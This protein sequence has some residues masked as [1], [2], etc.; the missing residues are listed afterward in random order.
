MSGFD[1]K[2]AVKTVND[3]GDNISNIIADIENTK[4]QKKENDERYEAMLAQVKRVI[5]DI[6]E[7]KK[8]I[9][10]AVMKM[11]VYNKDIATTIR[12]L[13]D[14]RRYIVAS[15]ESLTHLIQILYL[16]QN[17]YYGGGQQIDDVK[18]LLKSDNISDTLS[19]DEI[20]NNLIDQFNSLIGDLTDHQQLYT[21]EYQK[22]TELRAGYKKTVLSYSDKI[23]TLQEQKAYLMDFLKLYKSNKA[24]LDAQMDDLFQTKAQL[25]KKI[26]A[27][28]RNVRDQRFNQSFVNS[29]NYQAFMAL[30]D[31][32]EERKN[33][34]LWPVLPV[35]A[36]DT[37]FADTGA[38]SFEGVKIHAQQFDTIYAPANGIVYKVSDQDGIAV[39]RMMIVHNDGYVTVFTNINKSLV[40]E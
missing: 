32:R 21:Q 18:L 28:V 5:I 37:Y 20:M 31:S 39:N 3:L 2:E 10:E 17:D 30:K 24:T 1:T 36:I 25:Q 26:V 19:A 38:D 16:V 27:V 13:Q 33:F 34:F 22:L 7:T 6:A 35:T 4:A 12:S 23:Q 8:T 9:S 40:K 14:T 15:K 29:E 11:N